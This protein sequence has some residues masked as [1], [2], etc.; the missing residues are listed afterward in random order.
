MVWLNGYQNP[1]YDTSQ[2]DTGFNQFFAGNYI[3]FRGNSVSVSKIKNSLSTDKCVINMCDS[4]GNFLFY[5]NGSKV[6]NYEHRLI[7]GGDS[8]NYYPSRN[9]YDSGYYACYYNGRLSEH[10]MAFPN[11]TKKNQ[12]Y[13]VSTYINIDSPNIDGTIPSSYVHYTLLDMSLNGGKGKVLTKN[14]VIIRGRFAST[15]SACKHA[16]GKDWWIFVPYDSSDCMVRLKLDSLGVSVDEARICMGW[17]RP[18]VGW[19]VYSSFSPDGKKFALGTI[20]GVELYDFDRCSGTFSN[21]QSAENTLIDTNYNKDDIYSAS[22]CFS[23]NSKL[24]YCYMY[25]ITFGFINLKRIQKIY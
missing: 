21:R 23:P 3:D 15:V 14:Q 25:V 6:F 24:L 20:R 2:V 7:E 17:D 8:I 10:M 1:F 11:P 18:Q 22:L 5:S 16:N 13:L 19:R 4:A 12:F 9:E